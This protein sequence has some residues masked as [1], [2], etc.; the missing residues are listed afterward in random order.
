MSVPRR[1]VQKWAPWST[2]PFRNAWAWTRLPIS[3][4]CMS[5][6]AM[7]SVSISPS[8]IFDRS[9]S[10]RGWSWAEPGW[11]AWLALL[12]VPSCADAD[13]APAVGDR[14]RSRCSGSGAGSGARDLLSRDLELALEVRHRLL[15]ALDLRPLEPVS[16]PRE[17]IHEQQQDRPEHER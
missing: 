9:S 14:R 16:R 4:P 8:R 3:R 12:I 7:I 6:I 10:S 15:G 17:V 1:Y 5:V 13:G 11:S 2:T